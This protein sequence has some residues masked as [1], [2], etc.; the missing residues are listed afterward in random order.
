M[1]Q[2]DA[3]DFAA[4]SIRQKF[5]TEFTNK[6]SRYSK[7]AY[8]DSMDVYEVVAYSEHFGEYKI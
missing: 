3:H 5:T 1:M 8:V 6:S 4:T 7:R 2:L